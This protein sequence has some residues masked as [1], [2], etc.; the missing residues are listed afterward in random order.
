MYNNP[1][2]AR[3]FIRLLAHRRSTARTASLPTFS[4]DRNGQP[5]SD[6][7]CGSLSVQV[8]KAATPGAAGCSGGDLEH[9]YELDTTNIASTL[10]A[11]GLSHDAWDWRGAV[12]PQP[13]AYLRWLKS[14]LVQQEPVV[15]FIMCKGDSHN[16]SSAGN[17]DHIEPVWG[18]YSN[19]SLTEVDEDGS[20]VAYPDDVVVHG[21]DYGALGA[22]E[23]P[24]LY[25]TLASLPDTVR[26]DGNCA[27]AQAG[28]G[29]NEYYPC[30]PNTADYGIAITGNADESGTYTDDAARDASGTVT[31]GLS[32]AVDRFDEPDLRRLEQP[33]EMQATIT[34][35]AGTH[36]KASLVAGANYIIY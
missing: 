2:L 35:G 32:L 23:G 8:R 26:M 21:A 17:W 9:G 1:A 29:K 22:V 18:I 12:L 10:D 15:W 7:Y 4:P 16:C 6:G 30:I 34:V 20:V 5:D 3:A 36:P 31:V 25:R 33:A 28:V 27:L 19:H 13:P 11:L 14:H 24:R